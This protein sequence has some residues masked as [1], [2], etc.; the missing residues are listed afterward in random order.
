MA[1]SVV[2]SLALLGISFAGPLVRLSHADPLAIAAWRLGFSLVLIAIALAVTGS[3]RQW[4]RL[5]RRSLAIAL[6]AGAMLAIHF[7]AW[8]ASIGLTSVAASVVLVTAPAELRAERIA[9]RGRED[10]A[11]A[12]AR[13]ERSSPA[14][15][16]AD[17]TIENVGPAENGAARLT[18]FLR[19]LA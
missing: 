9:A 8:N 6:G 18:A 17:L 3:W 2:L 10:V 15:V 19:S 4:R 5:D 14:R 7:W 13:L 16:E 11:D 1:P 12:R